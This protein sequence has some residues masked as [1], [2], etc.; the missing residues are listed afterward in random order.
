[1]QCRKT[2]GES[3][4]DEKDWR[5]TNVD[6]NFDSESKAIM[7]HMGEAIN[8]LKDAVAAIA[9][10]SAMMLNA[11]FEAVESDSERD[12]LPHISDNDEELD[13][14][15]SDSDTNEFDHTFWDDEA[16]T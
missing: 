1:M 9:P 16:A 2:V 12:P 13:D 4:I 3:Q 14:Y 11:R 7:E 10:E 6:I 5:S 15:N 8:Q